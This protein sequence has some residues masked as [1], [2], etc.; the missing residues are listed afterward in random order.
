LFLNCCSASEEFD[1]VQATLNQANPQLPAFQNTRKSDLVQTIAKILLLTYNEYRFIVGVSM[2]AVTRRTFI[3][4]AALGSVSAKAAAL[5]TISG[6]DHTFDFVVA[7]AGHNSL[8][9]AAYLAKAGFSVMVL[10]GRPTIGGGCKTAEVCLPGFKEDL[11]SSVHGFIQSSPVL[12]KN[13]LDLFAHGL[14]YLHPD[15]IIH[16]SFPDKASITMWKDID[17]TY[18]EYAKYS[19]ADADTFK[20]LVA[21]YNAYNAARSSGSDVPNSDVWRRRFAMSGYDLVNKTFE[22]NYIRSF[23]LAQGRF[24]SVPGAHPNTGN[25]LFT[26]I[27]HQVNGRPMPK[28]GSGMLPLAL[29]RVIEANGGVIQTNMPVTGLIMEKDRCQGVECAD[30]SRYR[31]RKS[32]VS[33]IH[34][35]HLVEMAPKKLWGTG[36]VENVRLLQPEHAMFSFHYATS[37]PPKFALADGSTIAPAEAALLSSPERILLADYEHATGQINLDDLPLQVVCPSVADPSRAPAGHHTLKIEGNLPYALKQGPQHWDNIKEQVA[38]EIFN[39]FRK[40]CPNLTEDKVL[41]RY[42]QSPIDIERMNPAMW[43]GSVHAAGYGAAQVGDMRPVP[44]WA[45]Y[46]M[47]IQGLYQTGSCTAP[48]GSVRGQ[49]GRNAAAVILKDHGSSIEEAVSKPATKRS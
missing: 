16:I 1:H 32:V 33:T 37:E 24:S 46:R 47:P 30:G 40:L 4:G 21:E 29:S 31:A 43:R 49:P 12:S 44:G 39:N 36:F 45:E 14:E 17:R 28:G 8:I 5:Q 19:R 13:E 10:E 48:G 18:A 9:T 22:N 15:P 20:R 23:H 34:V 38:D 26:A 27:R 7:G 6:N 11:C 42:L 25:Q 2:M 41:A 35:K 3:K